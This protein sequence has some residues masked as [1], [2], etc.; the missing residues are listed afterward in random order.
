MSARGTASLSRY[1]REKISALSIK[2]LQ[3]LQEISVLLNSTLDI[4]EI[5]ERAL[6]SAAGLLRAEA[7]SVFLVDQITEELIFYA[8]TGEK[9]SLLEG[10]RVP[11]GQGIVGWVVEKR[12]PLLVPDAGKDPR[13]FSAVDRKVGFRTRTLL[14]VPLIIKGRVLGALEVV[15]CK[16]GGR[17]SEEDVAFLETLGNHVATA[18]DNAFLYRELSEAHEALKTLDQIKSH[19]I[20]VVS[21]ELRTP[22]ALIQS[23]HE[24]LKSGMMG[25]LDPK[26]SEALEKMETG[27]KWLNRIIANVTDVA[28]L[29]R[30]QGK[31]PVESFDLAALIRET[32]AKMGPL[33]EQRR[34]QY[35]TEGTDNEVTVECDPDQ[36]QQV[37]HNLLLNAIRFTPDEGAI[38][39]SLEILESEVR[40]AISENGIGIP[41]KDFDRIFDQFLHAE[42]SSTHYSGTIEF[43][44][45][46]LGLGL[47]ITKRIVEM[48]RGRIWVESEV[49]K[50]STFYFTLPR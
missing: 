7:S 34:Q 39:A 50:G 20:N 26:Q 35:S 10:L 14:C 48:H 38:K 29:D 33:F 30:R 28:L 32:V 18:L 12:Q 31:L 43:K 25:S 44:S 16:D 15:N 49:G 36:I 9:K 47:A 21:H 41:K 27:L 23:F 46:G 8:I 24:L 17:F 40:V 3:A 45:S 19:V 2:R 37:L 11:K 6:E 5:L 1:I 13:F 42:K 4:R 22:A